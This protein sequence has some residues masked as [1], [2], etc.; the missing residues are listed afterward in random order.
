MNKPAHFFLFLF[1]LG[2]IMLGL[3]FLSPKEKVQVGP[4]ELGYYTPGELLGVLWQEDD[5]TKATLTTPK[6]AV[7]DALIEETDTFATPLLSEE[8]ELLPV[9]EPII[10]DT[11]IQLV[12]I[13]SF[14]P[15]FEALKRLSANSNSRVRILHFGDS[16][17]EGDR[18]TMQLRDAYQRRYGGAG[19]G[20]AALQPLVAP[21]S[22]AFQDAEGLT[23]K[24]VFGRRDTVFSDMKYGHLG[25]FTLVEPNDSGQYSG[26]IAF[27]KR[28]WGFRRARNFTTAKMHLEG[29][30]PSVV[31]LLVADSVYS[32]RV[33]PAGEWTLA[34]DVPAEDAF[35]MRIR[36]QQQVRVYGISFES[37]FGF[38]ADN[39][40]MRGASGMIFTKMNGPQFKASLEREAYDLII[41]QF[42]GNAVPYLKDEA[43]V[44]R[45]ARALARQAD[46]L[47]RLY[48]KAAFLFIGPSDMARKNGLAFES[49]PLL[50][51]LTDQLR[52]ELLARGIAFWDLYDVMGG[53]GSMVDWVDAAPALAVRDYIHFTPKGASKVGASLVQ[54][55]K[56][57]EDQYDAVIAAELMQ[58][59]PTPAQRLIDS[60]AHFKQMNQGTGAATVPVE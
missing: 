28:N 2:S 60:T 6:N 11:A 25:S 53:S 38:H 45:F 12:D 49:Y 17:L 55:L 54:A 24:T 22:L 43:H 41:L 13:K 5:S 4:F 46:Y 36:S 16:Q 31:Q 42:G 7:L 14:S 37:P 26:S 47:K 35:S 27:K 50:E 20:Y 23:R 8:T 52:N 9:V 44:G 15:F 30:A 58:A 33:F 3:S 21:S 39:V 18:I 34:L 1:A 57:L 51:E 48:P 59:V 29:N 32:T 19:F 40:A 56:A 10:L